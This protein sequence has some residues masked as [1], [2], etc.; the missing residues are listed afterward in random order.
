MFHCWPL[1]TTA[2]QLPG[3]PST[4]PP[5]GPS[6]SCRLCDA[7]PDQLASPSHPKMTAGRQ[8]DDIVRRRVCSK[9]FFSLHMPKNSF[10][11]VSYGILSLHTVN[12]DSTDNFMYLVHYTCQCS[13]FSC[14]SVCLFV[15]C[16]SVCLLFIYLFVWSYL[17]LD[18]LHLQTI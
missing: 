14:L 12:N 13:S 17:Q 3:C 9:K 11:Q 18:L 6:V 16:L 2:T 8:S 4:T 1:R 15:V 10:K 7:P 5:P